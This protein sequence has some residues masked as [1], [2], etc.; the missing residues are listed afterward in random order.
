MKYVENGSRGPRRYKRMCTLI[1]EKSR[2]SA[3]SMVVVVI[4]VWFQIY[5]GIRRYM[6]CRVSEYFLLLILS[7]FDKATYKEIKIILGEGEIEKKKKVDEFFVMNNF[8]FC[9]FVCCISSRPAVVCD[10]V[11]ARPSVLIFN[12]L[13]FH[14]SVLISW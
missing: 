11:F 7:H 5:E 10:F 2:S 1:R 3:I 14:F 9:S 12:I 8:F 6:D 13:I 4:L